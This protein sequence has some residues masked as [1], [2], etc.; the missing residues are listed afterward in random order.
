MLTS[1]AMEPRFGVI[2]VAAGAGRRFGGK[3]V[4][5]E[6]MGRTLLEHAAAP[7]ADFSDRVVV[8]PAADVGRIRL[9]GWIA[10][11]G[12][13]RRRDSVSAGLEALRAE[14]THV[15]VH[16]AARPLLS[17]A[18]LGRVVAAARDA[19]AVIPAIPIPDTIKEVA[20]RRVVATPERARLVAVQTPQAF[21]AA[22]LRRALSESSED[23]TDEASL[24]EA[25]GENVQTVPGDPENLKI[26]T[27]LDL[28]FATAILAARSEH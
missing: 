26:T 8:L 1:M 5:V 6:L 10:T 19:A 4:E 7:F 18:L 27:P 22:L 20:G 3:K 13:E 17:A 15:L 2:L 12:G 16:D 24:V 9:P 21:D 25:L 11:A 28:E 23:A 14:T